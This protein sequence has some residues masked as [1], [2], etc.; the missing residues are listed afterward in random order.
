MNQAK[1]EEKGRAEDPIE[2]RLARLEGQ[3]ASSWAVQTRDTFEQDLRER[4]RNELQGYFTKVFVA[5]FV[6]LGGAGFLFIKSATTDVYKTENEALIADLKTKYSA[7]IAKEQK[8]FDWKRDHDYGKNYIYLAEFYSNS[9]IGTQRRQKLLKEQ[10]TRARTYFEYALNSDPKQASTY[11]ELGELYYTYP[12]KY[13]APEW[14]DENKA[15]SF[16][17]QALS[18]FSEFEV[19]KGWRADPL[20]IAG[21]I[22]LRRAKSAS[23]EKEKLKS[24]DR[25]E[26]LLVRAREEYRDAIPESRDYN[27]NNLTEVIA[28]LEEVTRLRETWSGKALPPGSF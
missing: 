24:L 15:I 14:I 7:T 22:Y 12:K 26:A 10:F 19:S 6:L 28:L 11:W 1:L 5:A 21:R 27:K 13:G 16:Y 3:V 2:V 18:Y 17:E 25:A 23:I 8:R 20:R 9:E 4:M